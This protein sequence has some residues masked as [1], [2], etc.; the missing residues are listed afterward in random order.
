MADRY[1]F[2]VTSLLEA[3]GRGRPQRRAQEGMQTDHVVEL[4]L[5]VAALNQ[6]WNGTYRSEGWQRRL[7]DFFNGNPNLQLL[8][9]E[10]NQ[11]KRVAVSRLI[12]GQD[13]PI[14]QHEWIQQIQGRWHLIR[15]NL[16]GFKKFKDSLDDILFRVDFD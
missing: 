7:V 5:V 10:E 13:L 6:L 12:R 4:Q 2:T 1:D 11:E 9:T 3:A 15:E 16:M 8:S 14:E